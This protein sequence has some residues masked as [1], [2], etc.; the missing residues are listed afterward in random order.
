MKRKS[1][2][3]KSKICTVDMIR[4]AKAGTRQARDGVKK[5]SLKLELVYVVVNIVS[6]FRENARMVFFLRKIPSSPLC[7]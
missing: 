2:K 1:S 4:E 7:R 6:S 3:Q 5:R